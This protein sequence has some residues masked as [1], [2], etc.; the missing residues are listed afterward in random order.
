MEWNPPTPWHPYGFQDEAVTRHLVQDHISNAQIQQP[1]KE[2]GSRWHC[3]VNEPHRTH[4]QLVDHVTHIFLRKQVCFE[5]CTIDCN[6]TVQ[7][8]ARS[9]PALGTNQFINIGNHVNID[10]N[11]ST[12]RVKPGEVGTLAELSDKGLSITY[13]VQ[14][15]DLSDEQIP[16]WP[17]S[18]WIRRQDRLVHRSVPPDKTHKYLFAHTISIIMMHLQLVVD[19][20]SSIG[21]TQENSEQFSTSSRNSRVPAYFDQ[22]WW[23]AKFYRQGPPLC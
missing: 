17:S 2:P 6:K 9:V 18:R 14:P 7:S 12:V 21:P 4:D 19:H 8:T 13:A 10:A 23:I 16:I 20:F 15:A 11:S 22:C 1:W 5:N 3:K